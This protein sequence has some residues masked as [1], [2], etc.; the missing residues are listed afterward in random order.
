MKVSVCMATY[1][2][3]TYL[4]PQVDSILAQLRRGDELVVVDDASEDATVTLLANYADPRI[5]IYCNEKNLGH[6]AA[7][8]RAMTLAEN[9]LILLSDQDDVW[10]ER[11]LERIVKALEDPRVCLVAGN[12]LPLDDNGK[13]IKRPT[14]PKLLR[15]EDSRRHLANIAG[16]FLGRRPYYG[17]AMAFRHSLLERI[18]P[19]PP[20]MESHDLWIAMVAN[21]HR[22]VRHLDA[23]LTARRIHG[24]NVSSPVRRDILTLIRSRWGM[25]LSLFT[26]LRPGNHSN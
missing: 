23:P 6:V 22:C 20:D 3:A 2:G 5:R 7:F 1:N 15:S 24:A 14:A 13:L 8:E 26:L 16:I 9:E 25:L 12:L 10:L 21:R 18:V 17:C 19:I 11:R 4:R